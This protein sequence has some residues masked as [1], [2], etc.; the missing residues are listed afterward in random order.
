MNTTSRLALL[1]LWSGVA[2]CLAPGSTAS[3]AETVGFDDIDG[4]TPPGL[5]RFVDHAGPFVGSLLVLDASNLYGHIDLA[6]SPNNGLDIG[7]SVYSFTLA[8][9]GTWDFL[10]AS[11]GATHGALVQLFGV[12]NG[13]QVFSASLTAGFQR[14]E[15]FEFDWQ[16][17]DG[18]A[19]TATLGTGYAVMDDLTFSVSSP[20][21]V[22]EPSV[23]LMLAAGGL[24]MS[25]RLR[26]AAVSRQ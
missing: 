9:G 26:R 2:G 22:P 5:Y 10:G 15:F 14:P 24:L 4:L 7:G 18:L 25:G 12:R 17:I 20:A 6:R 8:S 13:T 1:A 3:A 23:L 16:G 21:L 11:F 19:V